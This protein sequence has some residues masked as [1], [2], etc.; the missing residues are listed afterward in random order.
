MQT[1]GIIVKLPYTTILGQ[2]LY[3][4]FIFDIIDSAIW[5]ANNGTLQI[6]NYG[7]KN[8]C[9]LH[10]WPKVGKELIYPEDYPRISLR[11][12]LCSSYLPYIGLK[13]RTNKINYDN[14]FD[15]RKCAFVGGTSTRQ[16]NLKEWLPKGGF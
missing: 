13:P 12:K 3:G 16:T 2:S 15:L 8:R 14:V 10:Y 7:Y 9:I 1:E 11:G 4:D 6:G 5:I